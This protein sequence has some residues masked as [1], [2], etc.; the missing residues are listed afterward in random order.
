[1]RS[2]GLGSAMIAGAQL[3]GLVSWPE[4]PG[5]S[6]PGHVLRISHGQLGIT[7]YPIGFL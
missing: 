2:L 4:S 6:H 1:M 7:S 3:Q 5:R